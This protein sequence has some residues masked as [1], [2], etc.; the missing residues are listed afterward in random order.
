MKAQKREQHC[1]AIL[2]QLVLQLKN[3]IDEGSNMSK[4][5][6]EKQAIPQLRFDLLL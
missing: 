1:H 3:M 4:M 5:Q 2:T 6:E